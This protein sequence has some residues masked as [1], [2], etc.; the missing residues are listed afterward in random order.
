MNLSTNDD[1]P[2]RGWFWGLLVLAIS[3]RLVSW[4]GREAIQT[5]SV[6]YISPGINLFRGEGLVDTSGHV[7]V[8]KPPLYSLL[9]GMAWKVLGDGELAARL[10]SFLAGL[11]TVALV[12]FLARRL[13]SNR[14][15][16]FAMA[17]AVIYP[18]LVNASTAALAESLALFFLLAGTLGL[19]NVIERWSVQSAVVS[20]LFFSLAA[21][22][23]SNAVLI[24][25]A[26]IPVLLSFLLARG[27]DSVGKILKPTF[28]FI[29]IGLIALLPLLAWNRH[30]TGKW[31][32]NPES[33]AWLKV[34]VE[35]DSG[36]GLKMEEA[37]GEIG[38]RTKSEVSA[39]E[40]ILEDPARFLEHILRNSYTFY[41]E[42]FPTE[43][44]PLFV[45][46]AGIG[47][48][49]RPNRGYSSL[50]VFLPFFLPLPLWMVMR[51]GEPRDVIP[52]VPAF[53]ILA[54]AGGARLWDWGAEVDRSA[55]VF[56]RVVA[57]GLIL[58]TL[59]FCIP[60]SLRFQL[61][62]QGQEVEH[63]LMGEWIKEHY[64]RDER[65]VLT[66]KPMVAYYADGKSQSI[67][68]G[69]LDDLRQHAMKCE[70]KFLAV[71]S[72]TTAKV[73]PQYAELLNSDS[74]PDWLRFSHEVEAP[75]GERMVL[76]EI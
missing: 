25:A 22:T 12:F 23:R 54:G 16:I 50:V 6:S 60:G 41:K 71:D 48:L 2:R 72:R 43:I 31:T 32:L 47:F 3:F 63:R 13:Y 1:R 76:Y 52:L 28:A 40:V 4:S 20:A 36:D 29:L 15:G 27:T 66:R 59:L 8:S 46:L 9:I 73:Y 21:W 18:G 57:A 53:L 30:H 61:G 19:L 62:N 74:A 5:D 42:T 58:L 38:S 26:A 17:F 39:T 34:M 70:A 45:F 75:D 64:P 56:G 24:A 7:L 10:I 67:V 68:M 35:S 44:T 69:S 55:S 49:S 65:T 11:G 37:L 14:V 33:S 51:G